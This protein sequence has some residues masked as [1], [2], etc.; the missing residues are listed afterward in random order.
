MIKAF[1]ITAIWEG[2]S[3]L[4]LLFFA[5]PLKYIWDMPQYVQTVGLIHGI[6][7]LLYI[8]FAL[9]VFIK[10]RW[11]WPLLI[12]VLIASI[13]PFGTFYIEKRYLAT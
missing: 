1:K 5:M 11:K 3:L 10:F 8:V 13:I 6:L 4:L 9:L 7:F 2:I 12:I